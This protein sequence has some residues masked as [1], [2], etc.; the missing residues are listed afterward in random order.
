MGRLDKTGGVGR[1]RGDAGQAG[2]ALALLVAMVAVVMTLVVATVGRTVVDRT[3]ARTAADAAALAGVTGGRAAAEQLAGAN[4]G[5]LED[6]S[7][8]GSAVEA[9]VRVGTARAT[10]RAAPGLPG[11]APTGSPPAG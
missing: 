6:F 10:S 8:I 4:G 7:T 11:P 5:T 3:R 9:R 1:G 2:V